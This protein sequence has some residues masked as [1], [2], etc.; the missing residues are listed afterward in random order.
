MRSPATALIVAVLASWWVAA[1]SPPPFESVGLPD[2][3][4]ATLALQTSNGQVSAGSAAFQVDCTRLQFVVNLEQAFTNV[5]GTTLRTGTRQVRVDLG[6]GTMAFGAK[7]A[8]EGV[9]AAAGKPNLLAGN[10]KALAPIRYA[11]AVPLHVTLLRELQTGQ[12]VLRLILKAPEGQGA[13]LPIVEGP[14]LAVTNAGA[15]NPLPCWPRSP[16]SVT[17]RYTAGPAFAVPFDIYADGVGEVDV[18]AE[19]ETDFFFCVST[20][21]VGPTGG[22][23]PCP[24]PISVTCFGTNQML[25]RSYK[26]AVLAIGATIGPAPPAES[27]WTKYNVRLTSLTDPGPVA[28]DDLGRLGEGYLGLRLRQA[29][30]WHYGWMRVHLSSAAPNPFWPV[31]VIE[32]W[33][34]EPAPD[35][36]I[37]AGA[38]PVPVPLRN[39]GLQASGRLRMTFTGEIG[40]AYTLQFRPELTVGWWTNLS[41]A[42]ISTAREVLLDVSL[43]GPSGFYRVIEAE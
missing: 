33:A 28:T 5:T 2:H 29:D 15:T 24:F 17:A 14:L 20:L 34:Y 41:G 1:Q 36:A 35:T 22:G 16:R 42:L 13:A 23:Y 37:L 21:C 43:T 6:P 39:D 25:A 18:D 27:S 7:I 32:D 4:V 26:A 10:P 38:R 40:Q 19:G 9:A 11:G 30:G 31:P 8:S 12:G 3:F